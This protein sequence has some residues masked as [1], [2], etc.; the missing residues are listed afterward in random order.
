MHTGRVDLD[1]DYQKSAVFQ[2][3][4]ALIAHLSLLAIFDLR[5][6]FSLSLS[7][8]CC[9][10]GGIDKSKRMVEDVA[11]KEVSVSGSS[12]LS[13]EDSFFLFLD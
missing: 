9:S 12:T 13:S 8:G 7:R 2:P 11:G 5:F 1:Q 6:L 10:R 4:F 3:L